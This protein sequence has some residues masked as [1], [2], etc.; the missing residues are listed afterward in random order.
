MNRDRQ[1]TIEFTRRGNPVGPGHGIGAKTR[2]AHET[3]PT[4]ALA[5]VSDE[6]PRTVLV[7]VVNEEPVGG[8]LSLIREGHEPG[9]PAQLGA[10]EGSFP[11]HPGH[12]HRRE[13]VVSVRSLLF[14][15]AE[16]A[17]ARL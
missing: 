10:Q 15:A 1:R 2:H 17:I 16:I 6:V 12:I 9:L 11:W 14:L 3:D 13:L 8:R 5:L 4:I 7:F